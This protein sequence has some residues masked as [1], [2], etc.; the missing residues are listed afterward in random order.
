MNLLLEPTETTNRWKPRHVAGTGPSQKSRLC[1]VIYPPYHTIAD[2]SE[3]GIQLLQL[4]GYTP[5]PP[6]PLI[7]AT[8]PANS[9][10]RSPRHS[11]GHST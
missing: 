6:N 3:I 2:P 9:T 8:E 11:S 5:P 4:N 7:K 10:V 1:S